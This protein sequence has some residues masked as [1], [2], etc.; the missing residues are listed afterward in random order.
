MSVVGNSG[1]GKSTAARA[2]ARA[3]GV[4]HLELDSIY[5]QPG[6]TELPAEEFVARTSDFTAG[7]AWVV[8]GNYSLVRETVVWP[9]ADTVVWF[10]LPRR[11]VM[12]QVTWRSIRR[13][14][15]REEL[16]NGNRERLRNVFALD[17][18]QS[19]IRWSW[20]R[21]DL[22][23]QRWADAAD[24]DRWAH[25]RFVRITHRSQLDDLIAEIQAAR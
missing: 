11:T 23:R 20:T 7:E 8:D 9:R 14:V 19:M 25:L 1:S 21:H 2:L 18:A 6:W 12:R 24:D 4:A 10:D 16:W 13:A 5:H 22:Q 3:L 15:L 17:P